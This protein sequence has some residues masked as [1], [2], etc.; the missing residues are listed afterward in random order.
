MND[1]INVLITAIGGG[2]HG[3]QILKALKW[4]DGDRY[5]IF[6]G[7]MNRNCPQFNYVDKA[8]TLPSATSPEFIDSVLKICKA[9]DICA[10]FHGC[11]PELLAYSRARDRFGSE[12]ILLPINK[13]EVIEM[14]LDKVRSS[15]FLQSVGFAPPR[16][17]LA[18]NAED[19]KSLE[20][21]PLIVKPHVG[22]GGSKDCYIVQNNAELDAVFVL[23]HASAE[24]PIMVQEYVGTPQTEYTVGVL[25]DLDGNFINSIAVRREL[26]S[27]LNL[28]ISTP[29]NTG[30]EELGQHLVISSGIS[31]GEVC[32]D[33]EVLQT[34]EKIAAALDVRGAINIQGRMTPNGFKTFEINPRFSGTTSIRAMMD[35]NEPDILL[36]KHVFGEKISPRFSYNKGF[37]LRS[38]I[39]SKA[40]EQTVR[41]W[42]EY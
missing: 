37:V 18:E 3:E 15:E 25:H 21:F 24:N 32:D 31:M 22:S 41:L 6:G 26:K 38:L 30:K 12:G 16:Y 11:E 29:N 23:L 17:I 4:A 9:H 19:A 39:E 36:R 8:I 28:R 7:D 1:K 42:S 40:S 34:C 33:R 2:G 10:V 14:C 5:R 27:A 13:A 35:Y 20:L